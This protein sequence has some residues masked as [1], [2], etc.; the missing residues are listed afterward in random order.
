M[1]L[2]FP[3]DAAM[4]RPAIAS[5][6]VNGLPLQNLFRLVEVRHG[7]VFIPVIGVEEDRFEGKRSD[8]KPIRC[9]ERFER[10]AVS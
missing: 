10:T 1:G 6:R 4:E 8:D 5:G 9:L 2:D 7:I 3:S